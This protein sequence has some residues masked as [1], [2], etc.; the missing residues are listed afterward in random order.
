MLTDNLIYKLENF[1]TVLHFVDSEHSLN[2]PAYR[3][4][5]LPHKHNF[6]KLWRKV[7]VFQKYCGITQNGNLGI[8][9]IEHML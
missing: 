4:T 7:L 3:N 2:S 6:Q 5:M 1:T 9:I 8:Q